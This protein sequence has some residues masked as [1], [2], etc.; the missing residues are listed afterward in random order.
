MVH[1]V[2]RGCGFSQSYF[3]QLAELVLVFDWFFSKMVDITIIQHYFWSFT[4]NFFICYV[5]KTNQIS[6]L[7]YIEN[8]CPIASLY[9][10]KDY[11]SLH[12]LDTTTDYHLP[13]DFQ[14]HFEKLARFFIVLYYWSDQCCCFGVVSWVEDKFDFIDLKQQLIGKAT[15]FFRFKVQTRHNQILHFQLVMASNFKSL[16]FQPMQQ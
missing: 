5:V 11:Y 3:R 1:R 9:F 8:F 13:S 2:T 16:V 6:N 4:A 14:V 7:Y 15:D 10:K 12:F